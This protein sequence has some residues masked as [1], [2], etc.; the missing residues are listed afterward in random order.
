[1]S[2][3]P[4]VNVPVPDAND[5]LDALDLCPAVPADPDPVGWLAGLKALHERLKPYFSS[6]SSWSTA[7]AFLVGLLSDTERKN[8]WQ[9]A[10]KIGATVP[11]ALQHL[12][13]GALWDA[14]RVRDVVREYVYR[15]LHDEQDALVLDETGFLKKGKKSAG[16]KRQYTGT[17]GKVENCQVGVFLAYV[18]PKGH[19]LIDRELY[20]P[21]DWVA[22]AARCEE[23]GIPKG[24]EFATKPMQGKQMLER[25]FEAGI[26]PQWVLG[27]EVYGGDPKLADW[28]D[29]RRQPYI[30]AV[31]KNHVVGC[32]GQPWEVGAIPP[33]IKGQNWHIRS[34]GNGS[35]GPRL[36]EWDAV[37][38][39]G[40]LP[41]HRRWV[42]FRRGLDEKHELAYYNVLAPEEA[43]L[44]DMV[45]GAGARWGVEESFEQAKGEV[46]LD[47]Y[48]VR[49]WA[50]WYRH[51]TL[52]M[53]ALAYLVVTRHVTVAP[54]PVVADPDGGTDD[55]AAIPS[56]VTVAPAAAATA[57]VAPEPKAPVPVASR[58]TMPEPT[59]PEPEVAQKRGTTSKRKMQGSM[60][61]FRR[62]RARQ[63]RLL[64][65][66]R[67]HL[68]G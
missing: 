63:D 65:L 62:A 51:I 6:R 64:R 58:P 23:A 49:R 34:A 8:S 33:H 7:G 32:N 13:N 44:V 16:V 24:V 60:A 59:A 19:A 67:R 18:S 50:G 21:E 5:P 9:L 46:G 14:N 30:L 15:A 12:L 27:D 56:A 22:D 29:A 1:M 54:E 48:Q 52:S 28:L 35:K 40:S 68:S 55:T 47:Q 66:A 10:E 57:S 37:A 2:E 25:A 11:Y 17:A 4:T 39:D 43:D 36:Y 45:Q 61:E 41:G 53:M 31:R 26:R 42:L 3:R 20:V 38:V